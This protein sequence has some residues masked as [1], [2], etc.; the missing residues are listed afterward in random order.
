MT[1][2]QQRQEAIR[3]LL[4]RFPEAP[5]GCC[6]LQA[7]DSDRFERWNYLPTLHKN[8]R[9]EILHGEVNDPLRN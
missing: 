1:R 5:Q 4:E 3:Q 8:Y 7:G 9:L 6:E 2:G